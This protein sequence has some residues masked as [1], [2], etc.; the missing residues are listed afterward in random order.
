MELAVDGSRL[1]IEGLDRFAQ[2]LAVDQLREL[3]REHLASLHDASPLRNSLG[4]LE[5]QEVVAIGH[6]TA[7]QFGDEGIGGRD[8]DDVA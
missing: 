8:E 7:G 5:F 1:T 4:R 2:A 6:A 3:F